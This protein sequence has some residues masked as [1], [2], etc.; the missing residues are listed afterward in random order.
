M[1]NQ[2]VRE[3]PRPLLYERLAASLADLIEKG[4]LQ[5]GDRLPSVRQ[6]SQQRRVSIST[7][8]Q[9]YTVLENHALIEA[10]PQSGY[11]VRHQLPA[12][13]PE[14]EM[15]AHSPDPSQVS[16]HEL[17][18][19]VLRDT[20]NPRLVHLGTA[21]PNS[22]LLPTEKINRLVTEVVRNN[23][24]QA[25]SYNFPPGVEALRT[26]IAARLV[27]QGCSLT[28]AELVITA[29]CSEAVDLCLQVVCQPGDIVAI[30]SPL[31]FGFLQSLEAHGLRA[32]EIPTHP[33][34]GMSLEA[35]RFAL[36]HT[37]I[38]L[39]LAIP[40]FNNPLGSC[41]PDQKKHE[42]VEILAER[43]VPLLECDLSGEIYFGDQR[44]VACKAYDRDGLVIYCA[45]FS[46]DVCPGYRIGW[47]AAGRF[48]ARLE[49]LKFTSSVCTATLP[50]MV[51]ARF[52]EGGGYDRHLRRIRREYARNVAL[53]SQAV[54]QSFP[55]GTRLTRPSGGFTLW[56]QLPESV[57]SLALYK[58]ALENGI[59][60]TPGY[61]FSP[62]N[63]YPNCIRLNAAIWNFQVERALTQLGELVAFLAG[64]VAVGRLPRT[65][66]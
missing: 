19:M 63:R 33:R 40:T 45:S 26:H 17:A 20:L 54:I 16:L 25:I 14:P 21:L 32:L 38:R 43:Q 61:V 51:M 29:G 8:L 30:E 11:Y 36:E 13:L 18:M 39:V 52:L 7:V 44:P 59:T 3:T 23:G 60:L 22:E 34:D 12:S 31:Y 24:K 9:A 48:Q 53:M 50:Q 27:S 66:E 46:N 2:A 56:V 47:A 6:L 65:L 15:Q 37:D 55:A 35:L 41:M 42:L 28:P 10:R 49:W 64:P 58:L 57:D 4:V 1:P 62:S 5:P